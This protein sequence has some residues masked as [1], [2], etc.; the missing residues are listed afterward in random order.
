V[1][2]SKALF[3]LALSVTSLAIATAAAAGKARSDDGM[4]SVREGR[5]TILLRMRGSVIGRLA[6]G[7]LT[8]TAAPDGGTTV[9]VWGADSERSTSRRTTVYSG[10]KIRF[11]VADDRRFVVNVAG[12]KLNFSAVGRGDGWIDGWGDPEDGIFFDGSYTLNGTDYPTLPN[13]RLRIELTAPSSG[14]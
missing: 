10:T 4:L 2:P 14:G 9:V 1:R 7:K 3:L 5:A 8:V 11:R 6:K 12:T 13:E